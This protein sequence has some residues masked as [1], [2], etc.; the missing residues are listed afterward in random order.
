MNQQ[1]A[2]SFTLIEVLVTVAIIALLLAIL[3]PGLS[4]AR[5]LTYRVICSS[6]LRQCITGCLTY[7]SDYDDMVPPGF[8]DRLHPHLYCFTNGGSIPLYSLPDM[9]SSYVDNVMEV[10]SCPEIGRIAPPIGDPSND[11]TKTNL[12]GS[13]MYFAGR[14]YPSFGY[15]DEPVPLKID[16]ARQGTPLIQD[17]LWLLTYRGYPPQLLGYWSNHA[18]GGHKAYR[19]SHNPS[20]MSWIV[21]DR[22]DVLGGNIG[23][24]DGSVLWKSINKLK[25]VGLD[26]TNRGAG[27]VLSVMP[28]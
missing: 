15:P 16:K 20:H 27:Q 10:W 6:N 3:L 12:Y 24:F 14:K 1:D 17:Q 7:A 4:H 26:S 13:Y 2:R 21:Q 19:P 28:Q 11:Y 22:P 18:R 25:F 8:D 23:F 9:I 5:W